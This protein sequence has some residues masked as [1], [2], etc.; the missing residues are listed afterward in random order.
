[1]A[2]K[3][4]CAEVLS[5]NIASEDILSYAS[6]RMKELGK[7]TEKLRGVNQTNYIELIK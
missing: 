6:G 2:F 3:V 7:E 4:V 5:K 1:M